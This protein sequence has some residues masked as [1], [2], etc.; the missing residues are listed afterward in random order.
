MIPLINNIMWHEPI[1][2]EKEMNTRTRTRRNTTSS[3]GTGSIN[4]RGT[5]ARRVVKAAKKG[6]SRTTNAAGGAAYTVKKELELYT[7][8]CCASLSNKAYE[9]TD[10]TMK[11]LRT[12]IKNVDP[13]FAKRMAIYAREKMYLRSIPIVMAVEMAKLGMIDAKTVERIIQRPDEILEILAYYQQA[14]SKN[15]QRK[16]EGGHITTKKLRKMSNAIRKAIKRVFEEGKFD[17][18]QYSKYNKDGQEIRFKDAIFLSH[19]KLDLHC[20]CRACDEEFEIPSKKAVGM[21]NDTKAYHQLLLETRCPECQSTR[22]ESNGLL[23]NKI[24]TGNLETAYTWESKLSEA[25]QTEEKSKKEVW[26]EMIDSDRLGYMAAL[27]NL[28][29]MMEAGI[30]TTHAKKVAS[31]LRNEKAVA[32]SK[33]F[34]F[35]FLTA[36]FMLEGT[37]MK[38]EKL[39]LEALEDAVQ[40]AAKHNIPINENDTVAVIGDTSGSMS[41]GYNDRA[42]SRIRMHDVGLLLGMML[43]SRCKDVHTAIFG[44]SCKIV[45]LPNESKIFEGHKQLD[46]YSGQVGHSTNGWTVPKLFREKV[47]KVDKFMIFT[48]M[49]LWDSTGS[50]STRANT[51]AGEFWKYRQQINPDAKMYLFDLAGSGR[52]PLDVNKENVALISGWSDKVFEVLNSIDKGESA[53]EMINSIEI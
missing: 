17:E 52:S 1:K 41:I 51:L 21:E 13:E 30:D 28:R 22:I 20:K 45:K 25:G 42:D 19:P 24:V 50:R 39:F 49:G 23:L 15:A 2:E 11:R 33:Q 31:L 8:V 18:Y 3:A 48:D 36:Y 5:G 34:P 12:L 29:N 47:I 6:G 43:K 46:K 35:R 40:A 32:K 37:G 44:S 9:S 27:R 16:N 4:S 38:H 26:H 7:Q 14:N 10:E 53:V